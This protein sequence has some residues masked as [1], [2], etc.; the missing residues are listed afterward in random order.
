VADEQRLDGASETE[1]IPRVGSG[2]GMTRTRELPVVED[3]T[4]QVVPPVAP[5][6]APAQA[7][8]PVFAPPTRPAPAP[9]PAALTSAMPAAVPAAA[10]APV[11][12]AP[13]AAPPAPPAPVPTVSGRGARRRNGVVALIAVLVFA[14]IV[15]AVVDRRPSETAGTAAGG[16]AAAATLPVSVS[17]FDPS[18]GSGFRSAGPRMWRTQSYQSAEFGNLKSGVGL[19]LDL[20]SPRQVETVT[21]EVVGG[22]VA[23]EL[24]AGDERAGSEAGYSRVSS[25]ET[26]SGATTLTAKNGGKHRYWLIWVTRLAGQDGGYRA[27]LRDPAVKATGN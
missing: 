2:D 3:E 5:A 21:F 23:V 7:P 11:V 16:S 27:V 8:P 9:A 19:L 22:S 17:S 1:V 13:T 4:M 6:P 10:P 24:R 14:A 15:A 25:T 18:G 20:G 26:A 12:T